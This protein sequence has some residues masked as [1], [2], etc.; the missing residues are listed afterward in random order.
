MSLLL[1]L[2]CILLF[3]Y[4]PLARADMA[5][6]HAYIST[7]STLEEFINAFEV[8]EFFP[9]AT[10]YGEV[11]Q[12]PHQVEVFNKN[13][14]LGHIILNS[15]YVNAGGYSGKPIKILIAINNEFTIEAVKL[16]KHSE[17]IVLIGIPEEKINIFLKQYIGRNFVDN[18]NIDIPDVISGATVTV[19]VINETIARAVQSFSQQIATNTNEISNSNNPEFLFVPDEQAHAASTWDEMLQQNEIAHLHLSVA[20]VDQAF[21]QAGKEQAAN[22]SESDSPQETYI[23]LYTALVSNPAIGK[24]L[25]GETLY[26]RSAE[27]LKQ[28]ES[29]ILV[30]G[31]GL[32]SFKGSGYVRGGIFDRIK[33]E[34]NGAGFHFRDRNHQRIGDIM[35]AGAPRFKEIAL[36]TISEEHAFNPLEP[37]NLTLLSHRATGATSKEFISFSLP[38]QLPE[39]LLKEIANPD[40]IA[41]PPK[42]SPNISSQARENLNLDTSVSIQHKI[43]T[44][45][46]QKK[47]LHIGILSVALIIL[48]AIFMFQD[49]FAEHAN[50]YKKIRIAYLCFTLFWL[51]GYLGAQLSV[52]NVFTFTNS[53]THDFNWS[54]FL[55]DPMIFM[56]WCATAFGTLLWNR[57]AFCGWLCPFGALQEL[58]NALAKKI[59]LKQ[60]KMNFRMHERL[61]ALKYIIF[62]LLFGFSLYDLGLAERLSEIEPFKTSIILKFQRA[63]PYVAFV[64]IL[65]SIGL[66]I[67]R[68]YCRYLCP[69]G[70]ALAIPSKLRLFN[71]LKRYQECGNP[72]QKCAQECPVEAIFPEGNINENECIQCLNCQVLY[73]D[74]KRCMHLLQEIAKQQKYADRAKRNA[75]RLAKLEHSETFHSPT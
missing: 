68:F 13:E 69:L 72:C 70:A 73:H 65:L 38:Y 41:P 36:F 43:A 5:D 29:L 6:Q 17:P 47:A 9:Q 56:L 40:Y 24:A 42:E 53:L 26:Q 44:Q 62:L 59:G 20:D 12:S 15:D 1:R 19:M 58:T 18:S 14:K 49:W 61:T 21:S 57:G 35:V 52:V 30:A 11:L 8:T 3:S 33:V 16:V 23:D 25:L 34:Q 31:E 75:E 10:H 50:L 74:K 51:G 63:W 71:W 27:R 64:L 32:Y 54:Y 37:W 4:F 66:F 7:L 2:L 39:H 45:A 67:E 22:L 28:N 55:M 48:I 46:W 60:I